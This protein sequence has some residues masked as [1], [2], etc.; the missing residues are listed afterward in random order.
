MIDEPMSHEHI[1]F[2]IRERSKTDPNPNHNP[3][4]NPNPNRNPN[5]LKSHAYDKGNQEPR[6]R[7]DPPNN[8]K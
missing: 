3:N 8:T 4:P 2:R 5:T 1:I 7:K 6:P